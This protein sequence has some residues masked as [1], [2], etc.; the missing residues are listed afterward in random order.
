MSDN[1]ARPDQPT[2]SDGPIAVLGLGHI[3]LPTALGL[4]ELGRDVI[5][6]D[7]DPEKVGAYP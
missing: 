5:G 6:T 7:S 3:G 4:A 1:N 2:L